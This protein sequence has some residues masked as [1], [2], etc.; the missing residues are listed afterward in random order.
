MELNE[1]HET[2]IAS[3]YGRDN[4][5]R[6]YF[7]NNPTT[8]VDPSKTLSGTALHRLE[9]TVQLDNDNDNDLDATERSVSRTRPIRVRTRQASRR[10]GLW[11]LK[12]IRKILWT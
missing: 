10:F 7:Q 6:E 12:K 1:G 3:H 2:I 9:K 11:L 5:V 4:E 8:K